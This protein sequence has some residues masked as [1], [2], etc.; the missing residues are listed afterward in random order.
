M[1]REKYV[2]VAANRILVD[3]DFIRLVNDFSAFCFKKARLATTGGSDIEHK[4]YMG[5]VSTIMRLLTS[6]D[7]DLLSHFEKNDESEAE[8]VDTSLHHHLNNNHDVDANKGE[9]KGILP[10]EHIF[11]F[12]KTFEKINKQLGFHLTLKTA[13]LQDII[14]T[15]H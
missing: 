8:M 6:K 1:T 11:V 5:Q 4:N 10:L 12:C 14:G 3:A 13:G 2:A 15:Q 9:I 7:G